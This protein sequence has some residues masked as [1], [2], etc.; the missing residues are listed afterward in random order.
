[1][2]TGTSNSGTFDR[3]RQ[4]LERWLETARVTGE[5]A[6]DAV[7]LAPESRP[8][9]PHS[10]LIETETDLHLLVDL[11]GVSAE[12]VDLSITGQV[13]TLKA[14]RLPSPL[15]SEGTTAHLRE[16]TTLQYE[17]SFALPAPIDA[18]NIRAV[19]REGLLHVIV[20][21]SQQSQARTIPI[22]RGDCAPS[23]S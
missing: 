21:K 9:P 22:Q 3:L 2:S 20:H 12:G 14:I 5:R 6:L 8:M 4:E 17:R 11:P 7:G 23:A 19:V 15:L 10:D 1:M 13:L 16:R 18:E